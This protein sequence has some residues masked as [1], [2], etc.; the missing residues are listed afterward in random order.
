MERTVT[1]MWIDGIGYV[2]IIPGVSMNQVEE[3]GEDGDNDG[4]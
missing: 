2:L 3:E 4:I 1:G